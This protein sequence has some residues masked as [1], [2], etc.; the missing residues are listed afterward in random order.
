M[1]LV[2]D[3]AAT[4]AYYASALEG[5]RFI[6]AR[7]PSGRRF[8][9]DADAMWGSLRG[10]LTTADRID[11]LIRDADVQWAGAFGART[12][13]DMRAVSED[14]PFGAEWSPLEPVDAEELWREVVR[15]PAPETVRET[16]TR[17]AKAWGIELL[18][19]EAVAVAPA[20][21]LL[22]CGPSAIVASVEAFATG[23]DLDWA[24][25]VVCRA[26]P[27]AHRQLAALAAALLNEVCACEIFPRSACPSAPPAR[28][29]AGRTLVISQD[30]HP[31]DAA[32][33]RSALS[34]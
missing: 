25:Q 17:C 22:V 33:A 21:K 19:H 20:D 8:G 6:E 26:S 1:P 11:L 32:W 30:A 31:D 16:L 15:A 2:A 23:R 4:R 29:L 27:P 9:A 24:D 18:G 34:T 13:F 14:D 7:R 10:N 28:P 12:V 3:T 5:L